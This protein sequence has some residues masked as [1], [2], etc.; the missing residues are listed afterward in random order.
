MMQEKKSVDIP[1]GTAAIQLCQISSPSTREKKKSK[2]GAEYL[3]RCIIFKKVRPFRSRHTSFSRNVCVTIYM[4]ETSTGSTSMFMCTSADNICVYTHK[5]GKARMRKTH[6]DF[7][8]SRRAA[9][10]LPKCTHP[11]FFFL[12][13]FRLLSRFLSN[14]TRQKNFYL[15]LLRNFFFLRYFLYACISK[16]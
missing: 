11:F 13:F 2:S 1:S 10:L 15:F 6:R 14:A 16:N 12:P 3:M 9:T 7:V 4:Y 5:K 8:Q